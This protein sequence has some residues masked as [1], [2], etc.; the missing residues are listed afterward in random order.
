M[1]EIDSLDLGTGVVNGFGGAEAF[2]E[3]GGD[4]GVG[5]S[6]TLDEVGALAGVSNDGPDAS[7]VVGDSSDRGDMAAG[8]DV[9]LNGRLLRVASSS[10]FSSF[11]FRISVSILKSENSSFN[12]C[13]SIRN[14][15]LSN[16]PTLT[17]SSSMTALSI[18]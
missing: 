3:F 18:A 12:L 8:F 6:D 7:V 5:V 10:A 11:F 15:S 13:V 17:S 16:S 4:G 14:A 1:P 2:S 9:M